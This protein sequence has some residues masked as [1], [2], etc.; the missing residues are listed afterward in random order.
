MNK[1][2]LVGRLGADPEEKVT[3]NGKRLA[4]F[5]LAI[6]RWQKNDAPS[7]TKNQSDGGFTEKTEWHRIVCW[8]KSADRALEHVRKGQAVFVEG[9]LRKKEF[10]GKDDTLKSVYEVHVNDLRILT[11]RSELAPISA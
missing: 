9:Q 7:D 4:K 3:L 8:G 11:S 2:L 5:P 1:V 6:H 10:K